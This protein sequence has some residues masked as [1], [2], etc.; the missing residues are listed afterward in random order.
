MDA[1]RQGRR[2][3]VQ[4]AQTGSLARL[5]EL[6]TAIDAASTAAYVRDILAGRLPV[7]EPIGKQLEHILR[8]TGSS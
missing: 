2:V 7:P 5:P 8:E 4:E 3:P 6:P 1:F